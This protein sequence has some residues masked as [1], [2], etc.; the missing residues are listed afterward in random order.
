MMVAHLL[1]VELRR[2]EGAVAR[3]ARSQYLAHSAGQ[4]PRAGRLAQAAV[5]QYGHVAFLEGLKPAAEGLLTDTQQLH[6]FGLVLRH[7]D[8]DRLALARPER[9]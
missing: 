8:F 3:T 2:G 4:Q 7:S 6:C 1:L 5:R 9:R